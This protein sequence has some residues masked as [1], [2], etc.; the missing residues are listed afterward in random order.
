MI[1]SEQP[2]DY[3]IVGAGIGGLVLASRLSED[4]T[5]TVLLV[6]AGPNH[7]GDPRIN[8]PGLLGA[9]FG[10]PD[11]D[12]DYLT[13]PQVHVNNRQMGQPRG[14]I[15]GSSSALNFSVVAY[16]SRGDFPAWESLGNDGWGPDAMAPYLRKFHTYTPPSETTSALFSLGQYMKPE[17]Q[18]NQGPVP[19][20]HLDVYTPFN[21]A[22]NETFAHLGWDT[23]ADPIAGRTVGPFTPPLSVD[24]ETGQRGYAGTYYTQD[25][26]QRKNLHLLTET[27]V[28]R[29][30]LTK[31]DDGQVTATGIQI[32]TKDGQQLEVSA[33]REVIISAGSLNSPQLLELSGIGAADLL[34]KHNISVVLDLPGVGENLQDHCMSTINFEAAEGQISGDIARDPNVIQSLVKLDEKTRAGPLAGMP[35][36]VAYLPIVDHDGQIPRERVDDLLTKYLDSLQAE[37]V[38]RGRQLQY[39]I[40]RQMLQDDQT[41][42]AQYMFL[43]AQVNV[44]SGVNTMIYALSKALPENYISIMVLRNHPFS[45]GS[46]HIRSA[47]PGEKPVYDPKYLSHPLDLEILARHTQ[48]LDRIASTEPFSSLLKPGA[49]VPEAAVDLADLEKAKEVVTDRL[50]HD[51]HP[52]GTCAMMPAE[53]GGVVDPQLKVHGT[54]NLRVVDASIFPL[55]TSGNIQAMTYVVAERGADIIRVTAHH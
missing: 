29:V 30:T 28:E 37:Q 47:N 46:I 38:S 24:R 50:F 55:E 19:T 13:E 9:M 17:N 2:Y 7:M 41:A 32:R 39:N 35:V 6:E 22:W 1:A 11:F 26:A 3:I 44:K 36:S 25:V 27:M 42:S 21:Q 34:Q 43:N 4:G 49:R 45:R 51:F 31:A 20:S 10:D 15:V 53:L 14:R 8:T 23:H 12:W 54:R 40:L 48:F 18:G 33:T 52:V 16:P 5:A